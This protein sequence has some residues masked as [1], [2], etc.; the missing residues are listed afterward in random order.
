MIGS[1]V[2][3]TGGKGVGLVDGFV[4]GERGVRNEERD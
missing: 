4:M 2:L 3:G 1:D